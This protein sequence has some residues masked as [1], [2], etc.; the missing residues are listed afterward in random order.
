VR[1]GLAVFSAAAATAAIALLCACSSGG[2]QGANSTLP[3]SGISQSHVGADLSRSGIAP[4]FLSLEILK[5]LGHGVNPDRRKK[6]GPKDL[7][8]DDVG[9]N[10]VEILKNT[11]WT[12]IDSISSGIDHPEGNWVDAKGN[13]YVAN[14]TGQDITEYYPSK[15][16]PKYT[17]T[18]VSEPIAVTTDSH[19]N[20]YE[21]DFEGY[22]TEFHQGSS[23]I[24]AQCTTGGDVWGV[25][26][27]KATDVFVVYWNGSS[28][29]IT[30]YS[31]GLSGCSGTVLGATVALPGG[32]VLD[33][34][35]NLVVCDQDAEAVDIIKPPYSR[36]SGTLGS[37]YSDP[38]TVT[39]NKTNTQAYV[40]NYGGKD[41]L[42][43][44]YPDGS[45]I[46]TLNYANG[47]SSPWS[48]VDGLNYNP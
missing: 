40:A 42:V 29:K 22:V 21:G 38:T 18:G 17:Y 30:E 23:T 4:K 6:K 2:S 31:G 28:G 39:I 10:A 33:K 1:K 3:S 14:F 44:S 24:I 45:N 34:N 9:T 46:A 35:S 11:T 15:S 8:V 43:L 19:G 16:I 36:I 5:S 41:V 20:V 48:A 47:L 27:N 26:V 32:M 37:G 13:L 25:A 12:N 7:F